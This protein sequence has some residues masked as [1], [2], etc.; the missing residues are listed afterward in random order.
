QR[1]VEGDGARPCVQGGQVCHEWL[2]PVARPEEYEL[3][4]FHAEL[5]EAQRDL[6]DGLA[7]LPPGER[8]PGV[9]V[10]PLQ[11]LGVAEASHRVG[12]CAWQG[13]ALDLGIDLGA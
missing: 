4:G 9:T 6:R 13:A 12:E 5:S 2:R 11:C 3:S 7:V 8:L 10:A 1:V